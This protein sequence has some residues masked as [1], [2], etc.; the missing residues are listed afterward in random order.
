[1]K[2]FLLVAS[3][4]IAT[5]IT[6]VATAGAHHGE[7]HPAPTTDRTTK[8]EAPSPPTFD[9]GGQA[10]PRSQNSTAADPNEND[11]VA[12][13][14]IEGHSWNG[15]TLWESGLHCSGAF[16]TNTIVLTAAHCFDVVQA[17]SQFHVQAE[18]VDGSPLPVSYTH[19][20]LPTKRI[21]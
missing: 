16:I 4:M 6:T 15:I 5:L 7:I 11:W 20:T 21:V 2:K 19:L 13:I 14:Y 10:D 3:L 9:T 12:A 8:A 18:R 1:M 17:P